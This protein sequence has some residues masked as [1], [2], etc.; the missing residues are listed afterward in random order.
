MIPA[1]PLIDHAGVSPSTTFPVRSLTVAVNR[2]TSPCLPF[3]VEGVT[4]IVP[5]L[6]ERTE[7]SS[8]DD[9]RPALAVITA[10]PGARARRT[11][12]RV[13][14]TTLGALLFHATVSGLGSFCA[15]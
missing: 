6:G 15:E 7:I 13:T 3:D 1:P 2:T 12:S 4:S 11:P 9:A 8:G 14:S 10:R 5:P